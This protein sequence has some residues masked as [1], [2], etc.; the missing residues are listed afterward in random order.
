MQIQIQMQMQMQMQMQ[1]Q[2]QMQNKNIYTV[3]PSKRLRWMALQ[4]IRLYDGDDQISDI[5]IMLIR[6]T[7]IV[8]NLQD[9]QLYGCVAK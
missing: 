5:I 8:D 1:T 6:R 7:R 3:N 4:T 2:I 9:Y